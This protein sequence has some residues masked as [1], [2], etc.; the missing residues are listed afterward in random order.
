MQFQKAYRRQTLK[1]VYGLVLFFNENRDGPSLEVAKETL[2]EYFPDVEVEV[3]HVDQ[4]KRFQL[5]SGITLSLENIPEQMYNSLKGQDSTTL[6]IKAGS[7]WHDSIVQA[8]AGL[9]DIQESCSISRLY[10][11]LKYL[12]IPSEDR[13]EIL[14]LY[15]K[16]VVKGT[17]LPE[18]ETIYNPVG[19]T[20]HIDPLALAEVLDKPDAAN[21]EE[22]I[23]PAFFNPWTDLFPRIYGS[24]SSAMDDLFIDALKAVANHGHRAFREQYGE[25]LAELALYIL[26]G[27][28][29]TEYGTSPRTAYPNPQVADQWNLLITKWE[30]YRTANF[31]KAGG[32]RED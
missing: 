11:A 17:P 25:D 30:N 5:Q 6:Q 24:Y 18:D 31:T 27:H 14:D 15:M 32:T 9:K 13:E 20:Y 2:A 3:R 16:V 4:P 21:E 22:L 23:G 26:A 8:I 1:V 29:L 19:S 7:S 28:D 10:D 12:T